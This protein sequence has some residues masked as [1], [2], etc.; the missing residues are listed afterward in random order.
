VVLLTG[1]KNVKH[2]EVRE[3][4]RWEKMGPKPSIASVIAAILTIKLFGGFQIKKQGENR[5]DASNHDPG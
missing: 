3:P 1:L 4:S 5:K 2:G